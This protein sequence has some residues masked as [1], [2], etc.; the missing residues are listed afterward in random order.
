MISRTEE[1]MRLIKLGSV[2][3]LVLGLA[4]AVGSPLASA[5]N[6]TQ[7][8]VST[9]NVGVFRL[10]LYIAIHNGYFREQGLELQLVNTQS[11]SDAMKARSNSAPASLS[12]PST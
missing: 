7:I 11:G 4:A 6:M 10:P 9:A 2:T 8:S 1:V 5:Q 3:A 12:M